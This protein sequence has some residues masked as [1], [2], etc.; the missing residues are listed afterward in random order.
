ME[1][2]KWLIQLAMDEI[3]NWT[4]TQ[5]FSPVPH[6][7]LLSLKLK[8]RRTTWFS[9]SMDESWKPW[10]SW[11]RNLGSYPKVKL[12]SRVG[13]WMI[14]LIQSKFPEWLTECKSLKKRR[15]IRH[16]PCL[17]ESHHLG[18]HRRVTWKILLQ[19]KVYRGSTEEVVHV[20]RPWI[21]SSEADET[22][23]SLKDQEGFLEEVE[24]LDMGVGRDNSRERRSCEKRCQAGHAHVFMLRRESNLSEHGMQGRDGKTS[25]QFPL[26]L[27]DFEV[28]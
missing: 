8:A 9:R 7:F 22:R 13:S 6:F 4:C 27:F 28:F 17:Q 2:I 21:R 16:G 1:D 23:E 20:C 18:K 25:L 10:V 24:P 5:D 14:L 12:S 11:E 15:W 3:R 26:S 19:P